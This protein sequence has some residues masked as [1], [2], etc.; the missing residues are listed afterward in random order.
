MEI[1]NLKY[2]MAQLLTNN[3]QSKIIQKPLSKYQTAWIM[4]IKILQYV[5]VL[6]NSQYA[7]KNYS[8]NA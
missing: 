3:R 7:I 5:I 4:G 1:K 8:K 6:I 2:T